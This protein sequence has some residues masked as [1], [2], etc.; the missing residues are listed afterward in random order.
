M[1]QPDKDTSCKLQDFVSDGLRYL[2][3]AIA[4]KYKQGNPCGNE[5]AHFENEVFSMHSFCWCDQDPGS[6]HEEGC[7]DNFSCGDF[8]VDWYKYLGRGTSQSHSLTFEQWSEIF[9]KCLASLK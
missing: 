3:S 2:G 1:T 9:T 8:S 6:P 4:E 7:P 5:G